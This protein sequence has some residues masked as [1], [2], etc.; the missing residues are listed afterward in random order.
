MWLV[1]GVLF[2]MACG[3]IAVGLFYM[4]SL[5]RAKLPLHSRIKMSFLGPFVLLSDKAWNDEAH[6]RSSRLA[7]WCFAIAAL[8]FL[9]I[10][11]MS[12]IP[13]GPV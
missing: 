3:L 1:A 12:L 13:A 11:C 6:K 7:R 5:F 2:L 9:L 8:L 4:A 10:F